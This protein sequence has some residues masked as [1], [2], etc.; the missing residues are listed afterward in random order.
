MD[1]D[2]V[3]IEPVTAYLRDLALNDMSPSTGRSY[4]FDTA[5][6]SLAPG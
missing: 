6:Q 2:G 4:A 5:N 1:A 3:E